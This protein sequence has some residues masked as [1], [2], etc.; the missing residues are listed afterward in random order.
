MKSAPKGPFDVLFVAHFSDALN[1]AFDIAI[2]FARP[3]IS[4]LASTATA[5][6]VAVVASLRSVLCAAC[7]KSA[8]TATTPARPL[9]ANES[10]KVVASASTVCSPVCIAARLSAARFTLFTSVSSVF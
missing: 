5:F 4:V 6:S 1:S 10:R 2:S 3:S 7:A 8:H 9:C